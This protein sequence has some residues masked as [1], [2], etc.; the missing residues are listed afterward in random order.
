M[1][2]EGMQDY[3][4]ETECTGWLASKQYVQQYN[5]SEQAYNT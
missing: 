1:F 4:S 5:G 2:K 3:N